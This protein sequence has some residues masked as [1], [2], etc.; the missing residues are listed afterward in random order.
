[1]KPNQSALWVEEVQLKD[2]EL[3]PWSIFLIFLDMVRNAI[4]K[5]IC[6]EKQSKISKQA[7]STVTNC[8]RNLQLN[9]TVILLSAYNGFDYQWCSLEPNLIKCLIF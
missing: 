7:V 3:W 4:Y 8:L 2:L 1:M 5:W 9:M 6:D